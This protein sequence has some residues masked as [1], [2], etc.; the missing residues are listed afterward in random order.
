MVR[1]SP[2]QF[3]PKFISYFSLSPSL[4]AP[5]HT[6]AHSGTHSHTLPPQ[7]T[8]VMPLFSHLCLPHCHPCPRTVT[9]LGTLVSDVS[10][11]SDPC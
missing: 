5:S 7:L 6:C 8:W 3:L 10:L 4:S 9:Q 11:E 2:A 1:I